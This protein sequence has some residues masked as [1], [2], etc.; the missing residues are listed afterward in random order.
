MAKSE[1]NK[2]RA[3]SYGVIGRVEVIPSTFSI[4]MGIQNNTD[5]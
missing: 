4:N 2:L 3:S 5:I 1:G